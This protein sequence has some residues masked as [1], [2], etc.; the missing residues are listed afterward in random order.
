MKFGSFRT[1]NYY[2]RPV[3]SLFGL[4][5]QQGHRLPAHKVTRRNYV[6][7]A[8]ARSNMPKSAT[9]VV[10]CRLDVARDVQ[11]VFPPDNKSPCFFRSPTMP[12]RP[13]SSPL[14]RHP[15]SIPLSA[16]C[17]GRRRSEWA[18]IL[19]CVVFPSFFFFNHRYRQGGIHRMR[20]D[21]VWRRK[22]VQ[23]RAAFGKLALG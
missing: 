3:Q 13:T 23:G 4:V 18:S 21:R 11:R 19:W 6:R 1:F 10:T 8:R 17:D 9:R 14:S 16:P 15:C 7:C 20:G 22:L 12:Q 5:S 2:T